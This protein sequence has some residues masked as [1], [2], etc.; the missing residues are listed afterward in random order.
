MY[1]LQYWKFKTHYI[2]VSTLHHSD[3]IFITHYITVMK[4]LWH[5]TSQ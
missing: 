4:S 2:I 5:I 3:E 1:F